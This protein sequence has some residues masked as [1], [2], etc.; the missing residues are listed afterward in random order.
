MGQGRTSAL[1]SRLD[2]VA[3]VYAAGGKNP[4]FPPGV[5]ALFD[6]ALGRGALVFAD[7]PRG[8]ARL[9]PGPDGGVRFAIAPHQRPR[10]KM[11]ALADALARW[12]IYSA[13]GTT[14]IGPEELAEAILAPP[15]GIHLALQLGFSVEAI[16]DLFHAPREAVVSGLTALFLAARPAPG[17]PGDDEVAPSLA[18]ASAFPPIP[19]KSGLIPRP[20]LARAQPARKRARSH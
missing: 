13:R 14:E 7:V 4:A 16:A 8:E 5:E 3:W 12:A 19:P 11:R 1:R 20:P 10:Q 17:S 2:C 15:H 9:L 6:A 18:K